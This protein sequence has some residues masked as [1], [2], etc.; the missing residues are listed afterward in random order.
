MESPV[1]G[2]SL[3]EIRA[4]DE[5]PTSFDIGLIS[6]GKELRPCCLGFDIV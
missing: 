5:V 4:S 6:Q 3:K 2:S 1:R